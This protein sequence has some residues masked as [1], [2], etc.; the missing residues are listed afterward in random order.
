MDRVRDSVDDHVEGWRDELP[1]MDPVKEAIIARLLLVSRHLTGARSD[2][3]RSD[4]LA[5]W[6]FKTLLMLRKQGPP[7][8]LSPSG[9]ASALGLTRGALSAR[10]ASLEERGLIEREHGTDDR[11][12]VTVRL[13]AAGGKAVEAQ[14]EHEESEEQQVLSGLTARERQD[15]ARLL[16]KVVLAIERR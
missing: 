14:A 5:L 7:Y 4:S 2:A 1:W 9:L 10:L 8:E 3:L 13:T 11:R 15:L 6:Q 16:R 12:R